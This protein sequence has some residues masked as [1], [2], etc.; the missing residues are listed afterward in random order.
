M[1]TLQR[2]QR[3]AGRILT[4][5]KMIFSS[6]KKQTFVVEGESDLRLLR[7]WLNEKYVRIEAVNG[8]DNV[9]QVWR[10][11]KEKKFLP[12]YCLADLDYDLVADNNLINDPQ[13]VYVSRN[14]TGSAHEAETND[15]ESTLIKSRA[16]SKVMA[17]KIGSTLLNNDNFGTHVD[18]L[19][20]AI[21]AA[22]SKIGAF[23]AADF[24]YRRINGKSPIGSNFEIT[25]VFFNEV[26]LE[27]DVDALVNSLLRS[28][29]S[30]GYAMEEVITIAYRLLEEFESGWQLCRGHDLTE[31]LS[32][33][34]SNQLNRRVQ[35]KEVEEDLRMAC[36]LDTLYQT[37][38]G[39]RLKEISKSL[40]V[41]IFVA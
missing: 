27:V 24:R 19:R 31:I 23:R 18:Q 3:D 26:T 8:R 22:A 41:P 32:R 14:G 7:N 33:H 17:Q 34:L 28:S 37:G 2:Y 15:L 38:F 39:N 13:F 35:R 20:E 16:F 25:D 21:R 40:G 36:E 9:K 12:M 6:S 29:R 10:E 11:A 1:S 4:S 30:T 5:A